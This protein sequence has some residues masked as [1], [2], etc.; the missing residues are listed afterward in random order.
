MAFEHNFISFIIIGH[1]ERCILLKQ[2]LFYL[3][4]AHHFLPLIRCVGGR[5]DE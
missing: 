3:T 2:S 4:I 5:P 1:T